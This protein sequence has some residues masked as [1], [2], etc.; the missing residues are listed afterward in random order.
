LFFGSFEVYVA[1][2]T[3]ILVL[4][5]DT[6]AMQ[7]KAVLFHAPGYNMIRNDLLVL[8][9][10][11]NTPDPIQTKNISK[12]YSRLNILAPEFYI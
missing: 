11:H 6:S 9:K 8:H 2:N 5:A 10:K 12:Y 3:H 7:R 1:V 4:W